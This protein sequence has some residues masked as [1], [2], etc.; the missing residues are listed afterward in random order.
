[1]TQDKAKMNRSIG[2]IM[3]AIVLVGVFVLS[4]YMAENTSYETNTKDCYDRHNNRILELECEEII[5]D[6]PWGI[7][8]GGTLILFILFWGG[9]YLI[10]SGKENI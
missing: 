9:F 5:M 1:M 3:L 10:N 4:I 6:A 2:C 8:F 7:F